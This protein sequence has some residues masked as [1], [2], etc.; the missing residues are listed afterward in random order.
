V[1]TEAVSSLPKATGEKKRARRKHHSKVLIGTPQK[2]NLK[3]RNR[4]TIEKGK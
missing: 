3:H 4:K 1:A 2:K